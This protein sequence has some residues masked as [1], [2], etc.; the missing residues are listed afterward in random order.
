MPYS[1]VRFDKHCDVE[2]VGKENI[3]K[4]EKNDCF[5]RVCLACS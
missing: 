1:E 3:V 4:V 5:P 2:E